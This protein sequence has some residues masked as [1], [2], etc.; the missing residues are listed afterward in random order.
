MVSRVYMSNVDHLNKKLVS[1][2]IRKEVHVITSSFCVHMYCGKVTGCNAVNYNAVTKECELLSSKY[3]RDINEFSS[4]NG[5][6]YY[7]VKT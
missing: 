5:W 3:D 1:N 2:I 4:I 7:E 6:R